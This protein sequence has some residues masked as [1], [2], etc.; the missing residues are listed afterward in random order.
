MRNRFQDGTW[1]FRAQLEPS[2]RKWEVHYFST[3]H[4]REGVMRFIDEAAAREFAFKNGGTV[5]EIGTKPFR[6]AAAR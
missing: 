3:L 1:S 6:L 5:R 2:A 4:G